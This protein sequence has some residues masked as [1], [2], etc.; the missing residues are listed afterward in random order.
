ML[1]GSRTVTSPLPINNPT[2]GSSIAFEVIVMY[3]CPI[4]GFYFLQ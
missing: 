1:K 2:D 4:F 3:A